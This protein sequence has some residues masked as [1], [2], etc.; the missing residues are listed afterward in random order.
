M[1][2]KRLVTNHLN[3]GD[4]SIPLDA[5]TVTLTQRDHAGRVMRFNRAAGVTATLPKA[6]GSGV[7]FEFIVDTTVTSNSYKIQCANSTD[8]FHGGVL[9]CDSD[10]LDTLTYV[11]ALD[12]DG[13]DTIT[14]DGSTTGGIR[15][16]WFKIVDYAA[17]KWLLIGEINYT[18][19][20]GTLLSAAV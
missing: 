20:K 14:M 5:S 10:T 16:D 9:T 13:Y 4:S 11:S 19:N 15:G 2:V 12:A 8:E 7:V 17:G 6:N 3:L 1:K 18:G